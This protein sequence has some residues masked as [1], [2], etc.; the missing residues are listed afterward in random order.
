[1]NE[2]TKILRQYEGNLSSS[3]Q[4]CVSAV[5]KLSE[6]FHKLKEN[7]SSPPPERTSVHQLKENTLEKLSEQIHQLEERLSSPPP[8]RTSV[9]QLKEN[10]LEKLSE[11]IH[12]LEDRLFS[13]PPV[14]TSVSAIRKLFGRISSKCLTT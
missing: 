12:Q 10:A 7:L 2:V 8:E 9:Y 11:E 3:L 5:E 1:M 4:A 6:E 14:Q 13:S